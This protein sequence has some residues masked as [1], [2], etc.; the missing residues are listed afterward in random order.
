MCFKASCSPLAAVA[1]RA[2]HARHLPLG[3]TSR[4]HTLTLRQ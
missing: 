3:A 1:A 4:A 2:K